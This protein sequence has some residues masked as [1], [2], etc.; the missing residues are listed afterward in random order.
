MRVLLDLAKCQGHLRCHEAAPQVFGFDD[1]GLALL[2]T[3]EGIV[4]AGL[5]EAVKLAESNCPER[6][7]DVVD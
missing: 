1:D 2:L 4:P 3:E 6:A 5:E 7:I